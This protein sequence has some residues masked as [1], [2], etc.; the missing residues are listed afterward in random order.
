[1]NVFRTGNLQ[2]GAAQEFKAFRPALREGFSE[3]VAPA[4]ASGAGVRCFPELH[5]RPTLLDE[6]G[7][8]LQRQK[9]ARSFNVARWL[10]EEMPA[11]QIGR[12]PSKG[13]ACHIS[14]RTNSL[15]LEIKSSLETSGVSDILAITSPCR[16]GSIVPYDVNVVAIF[17]CPKF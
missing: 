11:L 7:P 1:M 5:L 2:S 10:F 16:C 9:H 17:S 3:Q 13:A 14:Q 4:E 8:R 15:I 6:T 12:H